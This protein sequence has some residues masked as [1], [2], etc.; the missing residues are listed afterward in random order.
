MSQSHTEANAVRDASNQFYSALEELLNGEA[1]SM[2]DIWSHKD[3]VTTMHSTG[4]REEG[5]EAVNGS[6]EGFA[7][8]CTDG[9]VARTDQVIRVTGGLACELCTESM[10][11]TFAGEPI[12]LEY[13]AT[14][15]YRK[16]NGEWKIVHHHVDFDAELVEQLENMGT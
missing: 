1:S 15:V 13:R 6:W 11:V 16:E 5:W 9:T 10:S 14:N 7:A 3:D 8:A 4:G 2:A 12:S